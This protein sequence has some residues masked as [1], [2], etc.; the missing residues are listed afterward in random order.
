MKRAL[1]DVDIMLRTSVVAGIFFGLILM[2]VRFI[3]QLLLGTQ[4]SFV[5]NVHIALSLFLLWLVVSTAVRSAHMLHKKMNLLMLWLTG[6]ITAIWGPLVAAFLLP[7]G[8]KLSLPLGPWP[9]N[10][11]SYA[12]YL[13]LGLL[14]AFFSLIHLRI[15]NKAI[16]NI[17]ELL[18]I[19]LIVAYFLREV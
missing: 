2:L 17:L 4:G 14:F 11:K 6:G 18:A 15:K 1:S 8:R 19:G 12:F 10:A 16:G 3:L 9:I 13:G 5:K 7:L